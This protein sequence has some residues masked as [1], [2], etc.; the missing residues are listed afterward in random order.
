MNRVQV[1][2]GSD[3]DLYAA[4]V[5]Y[6]AETQRT[7]ANLCKHAIAALLSRQHRWAT[8]TRGRPLARERKGTHVEGSDPQPISRD[9]GRREEGEIQFH[10]GAV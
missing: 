7:P 8:K 9:T 3:P 6:A 4:L 2:F 1:S 5:A 10:A